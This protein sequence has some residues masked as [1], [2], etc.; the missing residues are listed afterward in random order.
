MDRGLQWPPRGQILIKLTTQTHQT[1]REPQG[2][3]PG[4]NYFRRNNSDTTVSMMDKGLQ[5]LPE[6][7]NSDNT[8]NANAS[9][10]STNFESRRLGRPLPCLAGGAS[11]LGAALRNILDQTPLVSTK[12]GRVRRFFRC[13]RIVAKRRLA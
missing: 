1:L 3:G 6:K 9:N 4:R 12:K 11:A 5:S 7:P 8:H 13:A 2:Q 10:G